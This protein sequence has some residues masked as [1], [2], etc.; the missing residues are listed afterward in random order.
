MN[1]RWRQL[2]LGLVFVFGCGEANRPPATPEQLRGRLEAATAMTN[3][4]ERND[5]LVVLAKD[6]ADIGESE[7]VKQAIGQIG[8]IAQKNDIAYSCAL[9]LSKQ[10]KIQAAT[11]VA[12]M[13]ANVAQR[14][15]AL[16]KIAKGE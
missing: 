9:K 11:D 3:V 13:I 16:G 4:A 12:K 15:E 2:L 14:N 8:N 7:I 10:G 5:V 1:R 6:A